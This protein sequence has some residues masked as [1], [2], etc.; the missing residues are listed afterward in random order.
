MVTLYCNSCGKIM[1]MLTEHDT[2]DSNSGLCISCLHNAKIGVNSPFSYAE[3]LNTTYGLGQFYYGDYKDILYENR[4][5]ESW[6]KDNIKELLIS[7]IPN[8]YFEDD[9]EGEVVKLVQKIR[10]DKK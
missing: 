3:Y 10:S 5:D 9:K 1:D 7:A 8:F 4:V 2:Y 6:D